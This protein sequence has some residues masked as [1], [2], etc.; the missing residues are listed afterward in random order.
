MPIRLVLPLLA[1]GVLSAQT[2]VVDCVVQNAQ[3]GD[4]VA[5]FGY[6]L[7]PTSVTIPLGNSNAQL[8]GM[9][10]G[11]VPTTFAATAEHVLFAVR[12]HAPTTVSW[13]L[14]TN[15]ATADS[16][17][18]ASPA[19]QLPVTQPSTPYVGPPRCWDL[20]ATNK[21]DPADD[22]DGDGYCTILDC[23]G[24][25]GAQGAG[26]TIGTQGIQGP[27]GPAGAPPVFQTISASPG[28]ANATASCSTTQFLVT[29][30]GSCSVPN[31]MGLGRVA[32]SAA[33]AAGNGW[34]VS[35]NAGQATAVAVC[36][37]KP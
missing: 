20:G 37:A 1:V 8:G 23:V 22:V 9:L 29:G 24:P 19:C 21:C 28:R 35:C 14:N 16:T 10:I 7:N 34:S 30:G 4:L 6:K 18:L 13:T 12:F 32:T 11:A 27:V 3:T 2:P 5:Y 25:P 17:M 26:G 31:Q 36:A 15:T 33:S